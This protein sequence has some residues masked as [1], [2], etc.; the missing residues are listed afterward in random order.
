MQLNV[1]FSKYSPMILYK[2]IDIFN[3]YIYKL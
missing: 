3:L 2:A 1:Y